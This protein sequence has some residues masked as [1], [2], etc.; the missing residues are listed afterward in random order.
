MD[1]FALFV[2]TMVMTDLLSGVGAGLALKFVLHA[3]RVGTP[4]T[5]FGSQMKVF[6][7]KVSFSASC[8]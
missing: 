1:Q 2:T 8:F 4:G 3:L 6:N 7:G 5:L